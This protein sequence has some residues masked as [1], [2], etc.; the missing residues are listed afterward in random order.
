MSRD[1]WISAAEWGA[2]AGI[3]A[4]DAVFAWTTGIPVAGTVKHAELLAIIIAIWPVTVLLTRITGFAPGS[5]TLAEIPG[6]FFTYICVASVLE[7]YLATSQRPFGDSALIAADRTMGVD[8]PAICAWAAAHPAALAALK[9]CYF[10]LLPET[11]LVLVTIALFY[12]RR[13]RRFPTALILSSLFTIPL[14]WVFPVAGPYTAYAEMSVPQSCFA[15]A[16][17]WTDHYLGMRAH[18]M[19]AIPLDDLRGIV[20]FPSFHAACA[21]LLAYFLRG[22]PIVFPAAVV[23]DLLM[24]AATPVIG[25]HY[26]IDV[27]AGL[28]VAAATIWAIERLEAGR[29]AQRLPLWR[30]APEEA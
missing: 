26:V 9:R 24:L 30:R 18:T 4:L 28:A 5:G 19:A 14:L 7:Y 17:S 21:V 25:G 8:W 29:E 16:A 11:G 2:I 12:P 13:A 20:D 3:V 23:F 6:K 10:G 1:G 22:I 27:I 15:T